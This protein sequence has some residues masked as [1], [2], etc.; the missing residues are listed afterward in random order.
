MWAFVTADAT[1]ERIDIDIDHF[2]ALTA[3]RGWLYYRLTAISN[4][5]GI[6]RWR[7]ICGDACA[8]RQRTNCEDRPQLNLRCRRR[9][10]I[11]LYR[12]GHR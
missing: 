12:H 1:S 3:Q 6:G 4:A 11:L 10:G 9:I 8:E 2:K 7:R 5:A